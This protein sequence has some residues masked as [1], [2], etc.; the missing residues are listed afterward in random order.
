MVMLLVKLVKPVLPGFTE[1][2]QNGA[3]TTAGQMHL[4]QFLKSPKA[5]GIKM[6]GPVQEIRGHA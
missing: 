6:Q 3:S 1:M 4:T 5:F 2:I